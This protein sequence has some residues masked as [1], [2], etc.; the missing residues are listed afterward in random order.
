M[1][2]KITFA[3][4]LSALLP[5]AYAHDCTVDYNSGQS[6]FVVVE[7]GVDSGP[8]H[9][10]EREALE[11]TANL[12][13]ADALANEGSST[14]TVTVRHDYE[15]DVTARCVDNTPAPDPEPVPEP[16]PTPEPPPATGGEHAYFD[17][18]AAL[19][20]MHAA[21]T[22]RSNAE[23]HPTAWAREERYSPEFLNYD[24]DVD[25]MESIFPENTGSAVVQWGPAREGRAFAPVGPGTGHTSITYYWESRHG[26][27]WAEKS[28]FSVGGLR[29]H[30][31]Y[32][33][34]G[35]ENGSL[36]DNRS[37]EVRT[38]FSGSP[39]GLVGT[40]DARDYGVNFSGVGSVVPGNADRFAPLASE[41]FDI[42]PE[43]WT[44]YWCRLDFVNNTM[45]LW[46]EDEDGRS[47]QVYDEIEILVHPDQEFFGF[48]FRHNSSQSRQGPPTSIWNRN[49]VVLT[50][51]SETEVESL[52]ARRSEPEPEP[53][54][55]PPAPN[56]EDHVY[57]ESLLAHSNYFAS[58][59]L[60][61]PQN[62]EDN[63][64]YSRKERATTFYDPVHDAARMI[65]P[66]GSGSIMIGDQIRPTFPQV[67]D[68]TAFF[69]W[70]ARMDSNWC[71]KSGGEVYGLQTQKAFQLSR[72]FDLTLE[73]RHRYVNAPNGRKA[74]LDVRTYVGP[75]GGPADS[76]PQ[77]GVFI[78]D[79][80]TWTYYFLFLDEDNNVISYWAADENQAPVRILNQG[81]TNN[82]NPN[83]FWF[84]F[85]S[86]QSRNGPEAYAWGRNFAALRNI[87]V[88]EAEALVNA[89]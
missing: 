84:E 60:R 39:D 49:L 55:E 33:L 34:A 86:S 4:L 50:N 67:I 32:I 27:A 56:P 83:S 6:R 71:V 73:P 85:N 29:T 70:E 22:G 77:D 35:N 66:P 74:A 2:K 82:V 52:V 89:R 64:Y 36:T 76:M 62:V 81:A 41:N 26:Q 78:T 48:F 43:T 5:T 80:D 68:G 8:N 57:F 54:P 79:C 16:D 63:V 61:T 23:V 24:P 17:S 9:I 69:Y 12:A 1:L 18:L 59:H 58:A 38:L 72:D 20:N 40:V 7:D 21:F 46:V 14:V 44:Y 37:V 87:T 28:N 15:V 3:V 13:L 19:P 31:A 51:L 10:A 11:R 88:Q 53:E 42:R 45:S 30:K 65:H 25:A 47:L 75:G